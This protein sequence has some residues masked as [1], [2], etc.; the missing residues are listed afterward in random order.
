MRRRP[1]GGIDGG[2]IRQHER[3]DGQFFPLRGRHPR[4]RAQIQPDIHIKASLMACM[5]PG[6]GTAPRLRDVADPEIRQPGGARPAG[7]MR[8][9]G[10]AGR[11]SPV[12]VPRDPDGLPTRSFR[13][14][15]HA[16]GQAP[17]RRCSDGTGGARG[18]TGR[19][20]P[21]RSTGKGA[22]RGLGIG[23]RQAQ[24]PGRQQQAAEARGQKRLSNTVTTSP[25]CSKAWR[26]ARNS[27]AR[28]SSVTRV[29]ET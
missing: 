21:I 12:P 13:R 24:Q 25:G 23:C 18:R 4:L 16:P 8:N 5:A 27:W 26:S 15:G 7:N 29:T 9:K 17:K 14:Q 19:H 28:P 3:G 10:D 1:A 6:K 20:R 2:F 11:M 22:L